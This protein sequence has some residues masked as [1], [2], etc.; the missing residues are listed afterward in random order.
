MNMKSRF[1]GL[2]FIFISAGYLFAQEDILAAARQNKFDVV[3]KMLQEN[4]SLINEIEAGG[5]YHSEDPV[6][7]EENIVTARGGQAAEEFAETVSRLLMAD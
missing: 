7:C 5:G 1:F 3:K 6:T 2:L 4:E